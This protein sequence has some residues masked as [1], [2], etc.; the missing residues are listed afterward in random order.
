VETEVA[1]KP[2]IVIPIEK[3]HKAPPAE[4]PKIVIPIEK[5][6]KALH[7]K[8][9]LGWFHAVQRHEVRSPA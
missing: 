5:L 1:E 6:G 2:K 7:P 4:K 8:P 3:F 9:S